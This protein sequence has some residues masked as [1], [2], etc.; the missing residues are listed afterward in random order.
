M[1]HEV[2]IRRFMFGTDYPHP[3]GTW[4]NT[5][6]WIKDAFDGVPLEDARLILGQNAAECYGLDVDSLRGVTKRIG[7]RPEELFGGGPISEELRAQ[8]HDRS[9]YLRPAERVTSATY[10]AMIAADETGLVTLAV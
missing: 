6:D 5:Q 7:P 3:E 1:R 4:P 9:G 8:F 10:D 2:G